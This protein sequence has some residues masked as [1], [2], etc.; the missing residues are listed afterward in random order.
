MNRVSRVLVALAVFPTLMLTSCTL[1]PWAVAQIKTTKKVEAKYAVPKGKVI[2]AL[3]ESSLVDT[4]QPVAMLLTERINRRFAK[5]KVAASTVPYSSVLDLAAA[6]PGYGEMRPADVGKKLGADI[7]CYVVLYEFSLKDRS[8]GDLWRGK[9]QGA[10]CLV[11]AGTGKRLWPIGPLEGYQL[12]PVTTPPTAES[13]PDY[14]EEL[15]QVLCESMADRVAKLFYDHKIPIDA[16]E[17]VEPQD[18]WTLE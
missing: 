5:A 7:V 9:M 15:T 11:D 18:I 4:D 8:L 13:S 3:V 2:L 1:I 6:T 16:E 14:S 12:K 10:V 17:D